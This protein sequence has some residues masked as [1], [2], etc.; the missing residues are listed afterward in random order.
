MFCSFLML[1]LEDM[2]HRIEAIVSRT[3]PVHTMEKL[4]SRKDLKSVRF[5]S[6]KRIPFV[7]L[8]SIGGGTHTHTPTKT[9]THLSAS[10]SCRASQRDLLWSSEGGCQGFLKGQGFLRRGPGCPRAG[11][12]DRGERSLLFFAGF[13]KLLVIRTFFRASYRD[14]ACFDLRPSGV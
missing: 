8:C 6:N 1:T 13:P 9:S 2:P 11:G 4:N 14:L 10:A 7:S 3:P 5:G 12:E